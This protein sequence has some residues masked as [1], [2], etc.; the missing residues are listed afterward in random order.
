MPR[1][2][3]TSPPLPWVLSASTPARLS[4]GAR[5]LHERVLAHPEWNVIDIGYSLAVRRGEDGCRAVIMGHDRSELLAGLHA[6]TLGDCGPNVCIGRPVGR[7]STMFVVPAPDVDALLG[8][9]GLLREVPVFAGP[10]RRCSAVLAEHLGWDVADLLARADTSIPDAVE[11]L[12]PAG[13]AVQVALAMAW[14]SYGVV[15]DLVVGETGSTLAV[16][17]IAGRFRMADAAEAIVRSPARAR[18]DRDRL[19]EQLRRATAHG[20]RTMIEISPRPVLAA[21]CASTVEA[22]VEVLPKVS[23]DRAAGAITF[24]HTVARAYVCGARVGWPA[25]FVGRQAVLVDL[26]PL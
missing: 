9:R 20:A 24:A 6:L 5:R 10:L 21:E 1:P 17:V 25:R 12:G 8:A 11:V 7:P 15:P 14:R 18:H 16:E 2:P 3:T 22:N 13:F 19:H 4:A 23:S 26:P